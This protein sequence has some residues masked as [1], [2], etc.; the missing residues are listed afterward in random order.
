MTTTARKKI[1]VADD[2]E[3]VLS[4]LEATLGSDQRYELFLARDGKEAVKLCR[5]HHPDLVLLDVMMP[6]Q[7]GLKTCRIL[8]RDPQ[9]ADIVIIML[10]AMSQNVDIGEGAK[11]GADEYMT[12]PFSPSELITKIEAV[13]LQ[14]SF[15]RGERVVLDTGQ[16]GVIEKRVSL[17]T[18][19]Q[20][21]IAYHVKLDDGGTAM[22]SSGHVSVM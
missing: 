1:L 10:T 3:I 6:E 15:T 2:D 22:V 17:S 5:E 12:K 9:T 20:D 11:A 13:R 4:V 18:L 7:D 21:D 14:R 19:G 8:K 16:T